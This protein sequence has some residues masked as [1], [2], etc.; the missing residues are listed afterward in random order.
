MYTI[1]TIILAAA[2]I[3]DM[4]SGTT[5]CDSFCRTNVGSASYCKTGQTPPVCHGST[6]ACCTT[7]I[8]PQP[9][10]LVRPAISSSVVLIVTTSAPT[11]TTVKTT[12]ASTR[13]SSST[14]TT[15]RATTTTTT[16]RT[17]TTTATT[18][19][20][21]TAS[22]TTSGTTT[23]AITTIKAVTTNAQCENYPS[24]TVPMTLWVEG[25]P[26]YEISD[27]QAFY[28]R[29]A[30]FIVSNCV[31]LETVSLV[32][33]TPHPYFV[34]NGNGGYAYW[35]PQTSPIYTH[36][37]QKLPSTLATKINVLL[38]PY[39]YDSFAR[40]KWSTFA[41]ANPSTNKI[42][43]KTV[44]DGIYSFVLGWQNFVSSISTSRLSISGYMIDYEEILRRTGTDNLVSF[45]AADLAPY[46]AAYPTIKTAISF[47]YDDKNRIN[48]YGP[49]FDFLHLQVYDLY[50]PYIGADESLK[51]SLFVKFANDPTGLAN[52]IMANVLTPNILSFYAGR[53]KQITLMWSTQYISEKNCLYPLGAGASCGINYEIHSTP[54]AFNQ[55]VQSI[56]GRG[57]AMAQVQHA[58]YTFNF[59]QQTWL[60][61]N[62]RQ[63]R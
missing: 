35:P 57:G 47:G 40:G 1:S 58:V 61:I 4:G 26:Y 34:S 51:D 28:T 2:T 13:A 46:R 49:Y 17:T 39:I 43:S 3:V 20:T 6:L 62:Q 19:T 16:K 8:V 44:Y 33:R 59:M 11:T 30:S 15:T 56:R 50:Y 41:T 7:A 42:G 38:Y 10:T 53:E 31:N 29:L 60:P 14:T 32:I 48:L 45:T 5:S 55:F 54:I 22:T 24:S 18:R 25:P 63:A 52:T 37:L 12:T 23:T 36:L 9:T 21:T 27:F